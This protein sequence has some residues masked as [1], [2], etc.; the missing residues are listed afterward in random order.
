MVQVNT[1][2]ECIIYRTT[3][4]YP[5]E[6]IKNSSVP[7]SGKNREEGIYAEFEF[8]LFQM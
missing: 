8:L 7:F 5:N 3:E 4:R 2:E 1:L 6:G